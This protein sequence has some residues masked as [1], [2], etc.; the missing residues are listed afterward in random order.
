MEGRT[1][2]LSDPQQSGII[3]Q[4]PVDA[5]LSQPSPKAQSAGRVGLIIG[6]NY[7]ET[8]IGQT[9][10]GARFK[11][12]GLLSRCSRQTQKQT[13]LIGNTR[14]LRGDTN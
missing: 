14:L 11:S 10:G 2:M 4:L 5:K 7:I 3:Y 9:G 8:H 1:A 6:S 12:C 13:R